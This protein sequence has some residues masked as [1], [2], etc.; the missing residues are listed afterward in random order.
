MDRRQSPLKHRY[1]VGLRPALDHAFSGMGSSST[2]EADQRS[3]FTA[4]L[5]VTYLRGAGKG[6]PFG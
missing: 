6:D 3:A 1:Y 4:E 2:A 5:H